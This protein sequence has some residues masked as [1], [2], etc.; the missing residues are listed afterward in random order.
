MLSSSVKNAI[1]PL[2]SYKNKFIE[3]NRILP[4]LAISLSKE[5]EA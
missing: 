2:N 5:V 4:D 3:A 1:E